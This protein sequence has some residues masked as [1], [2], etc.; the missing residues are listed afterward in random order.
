MATQPA[1]QIIGQPR[2][3]HTPGRYDLAMLFVVTA[4]L[5]FGLVMVFSSSYPRGLEGFD[6]PGFGAAFAAH[7]LFV[8][9]GLGCQHD[10]GRETVRSELFD[11]G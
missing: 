9:G 6:D 2:G 4:M 3:R 11:C 5:G 8:G 7:L 10:D 1:R